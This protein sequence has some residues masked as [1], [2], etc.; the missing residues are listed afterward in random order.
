MTGTD[1][2]SEMRRCGR[3]DRHSCV[4]SGKMTL[5]EELAAMSLSF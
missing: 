2:Q 4:Y 1:M 3:S 5:S